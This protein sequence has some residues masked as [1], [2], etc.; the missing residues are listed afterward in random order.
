MIFS[1]SLVESL[2]AKE[3]QVRISNF[4][5]CLINE[6]KKVRINKES[7]VNGKDS[8]KSADSL[9]K[10]V[11][12]ADKTSKL[13]ET[14]DQPQQHNPFKNIYIE[15][16]KLILTQRSEQSILFKNINLDLSYQGIK[17]DQIDLH[18]NVLAAKDLKNESY[19]LHADLHSAI[20][21][22]DHKNIEASVNLSGRM[23]DG[24]FKFFGYTQT[25]NQKLMFELTHV[26]F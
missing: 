18:A 23:L 8:V 24:E 22:H 3:V 17:I 9:K 10:I 25:L 2:R 1:G 12:E 5:N 20:K 21:I 6:T 14:I 16:L 26:G 19:L 4:N 11:S 7:L 13:A 15:Q